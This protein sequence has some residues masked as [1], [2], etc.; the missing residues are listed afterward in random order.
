MSID[1]LAE[2]CLTAK[3]KLYKLINMRTLAIANQK[4]GV[5]KTTTAINLGASLAAAGR[6]VLLVDI[7]P[8]SSLTMA[9]VG[10][11]S[12]RS[13]AQVLGDTHPGSKSITEIIQPIAEGLDLA[14][15]DLALSNSELGLV[16]RYNREFVLQKALAPMAKRYDVAIVD[17]GPS[18]GLLVVNALA[19]AQGVICP[20]LPTAL[21]LRGLQLFL[22][23][24]GVVQREINPQLQLLGVLVCQ[25]DPRLKLHQAALADIHESGLPVFQV[26]IG[27]SIRVAESAG[28]GAPINRGNLANQY[29]TLARQ[30]EKWLTSGN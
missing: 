19:A 26:V 23:S 17:C 2:G 28:A 15:S 16:T 20:T 18:L 12:D 27:K 7:D 24:L 3:E 9:T 5:G 4:G 14:P 29:Q 10:D 30:V 1:T 21:D 25:Y 13:L 8:Q 11:C 6:R 22:E